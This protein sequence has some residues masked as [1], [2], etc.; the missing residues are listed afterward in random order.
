M[1]SQLMEIIHNI[2]FSNNPFTPLYKELLIIFL[3]WAN[4]SSQGF[5]SGL[6]A[7]RKTNCTPKNK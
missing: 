1:F 7:G 2:T 4:T 3:I 6:Y 5:N